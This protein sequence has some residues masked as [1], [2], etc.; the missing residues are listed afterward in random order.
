MSQSGTGHKAPARRTSV[1]WQS[2]SD[3]YQN[4]LFILCANDE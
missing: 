4:D 3:L 2:D 1:Y